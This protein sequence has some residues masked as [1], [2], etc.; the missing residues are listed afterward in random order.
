MDDCANATNTCEKRYINII[1]SMPLEVIGDGTYT[2]M[3][4]CVNMRFEPCDAPVPTCEENKE[5][6]KSQFYELLAAFGMASQDGSDADVA[7]NEDDE[8]Q[9]EP[10]VRGDGDEDIG[11]IA[12]QPISGSPDEAAEGERS[13]SPPSEISASLLDVLPFIIQRGDIK[14]KSVSQ[15]RSSKNRDRRNSH[16][17]TSRNYNRP[18][19]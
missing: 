12:G 14:R 1:L 17:F 11:T 3:S 9:T 2:I 15:G 6:F 4:D 8:P 13:E 19:I 10:V 7:A 16:N 5:R 18:S